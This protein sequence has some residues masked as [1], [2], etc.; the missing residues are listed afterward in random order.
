MRGL[1]A[2]TTTTCESGGARSPLRLRRWRSAGGPRGV[3]RLR[4][5]WR[6]VPQI[7]KDGPVSEIKNHSPVIWRCSRCGALTHPSEERTPAAWCS[8]CG[9]VT[10]AHRD[11]G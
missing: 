1:L 9:R 11:G 6:D 5:N 2:D 8:R 4:Q 10:E 7:R 3:P